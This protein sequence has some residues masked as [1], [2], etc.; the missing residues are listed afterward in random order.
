MSF[1]HSCAAGQDGTFLPG[2]PSLSPRPLGAFS[3][4]GKRHVHPSHDPKMPS[5]WPQTSLVD[6]QVMYFKSY[7]KEIE[8]KLACHAW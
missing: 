1:S 4:G 5:A 8:R 3:P 7:I 6:G 2:R